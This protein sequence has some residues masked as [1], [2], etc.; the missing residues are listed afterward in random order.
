MANLLYEHIWQ[1]FSL[2]A[3]WSNLIIL[4]LLIYSSCEYSSC[5][6]RRCEYRSCEYSSCEFTMTGILII[7]SFCVQYIREPWMHK[8]SRNFNHSNEMFPTQSGWSVGNLFYN[9]YWHF[10][11]FNISRYPGLRIISYQTEMYSIRLQLF[12]AVEWDTG[13]TRTRAH[14]TT[15]AWCLTHQRRSLNRNGRFAIY[16][17]CCNNNLTFVLIMHKRNVTNKWL[18]NT[19]MIPRRCVECQSLRVYAQRNQRPKWPIK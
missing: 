17:L 14:L 6:Y 2:I 10:F 19:A 11:Q 8:C 18:L 4:F 15:F 12:K 1:L 9:H 16:F 13:L 3:V 7:L 5:E